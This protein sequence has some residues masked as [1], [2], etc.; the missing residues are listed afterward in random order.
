[1]EELAFPQHTTPRYAVRDL[2][3]T[4]LAVIAS[5]NQQSQL[6]ADEF[7]REAK[8][9]GAEIAAAVSYSKDSSDLREQFMKIREAGATDD[10]SISFAARFS[11]AQLRSMIRAGADPD[12]LEEARRKRLTVSVTKLFGPR[13][14]RIVDSLHLPYTTS[15]GETYN[16]EI[17]VTGIQGIFAAIG[18][19]EEIGII[20]SQMS[21][22]NVNAQLLGSGEWYDAVQL[23]ANKRYVDGALFFS[24][25][26]ADKL[27]SSYS[28]FERSFLSSKKQPPTRNTLYGFDTM[29][30]VLTL[31]ERGA[32]TR[33]Q[34]AQALENVNEYRGL[35]ATISLRHGRV[36]T[37]V[38]ILQFKNNEII[39]VAE[40]NVN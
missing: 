7:A 12:I 21:Y 17:P 38:H 2:G 27:D 22:F 26:F 1:M 37:H 31:I 24:D 30:L 40:A 9:L 14:K 4:K 29:E 25:S 10:P 35:H 34:L 6:L 18:E 23:E 39:N 15:L 19:S 33:E 11:R 20:G 8:S 36:N 16:I 13:G 32:T 3:M 5:D 28:A